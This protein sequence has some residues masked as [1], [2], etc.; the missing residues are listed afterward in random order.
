M[1]R[2]AKTAPIGTHPFVSPF[3]VLMRSGFTPK[4]SAARRAARTHP[5][6]RRK[7]KAEQLSFDGFGNS[8]AA[9]TRVHTPKTGSALQKFSTVRRDVIHSLRR[10][11]SGA[12]P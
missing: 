4:Y 3:A 5:A 2:F 11:A 7:I 9:V 8:F 10:R 12:R 6:C 1:T